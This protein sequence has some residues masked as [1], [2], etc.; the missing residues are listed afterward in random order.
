[1]YF[2]KDYQIWRYILIYFGILITI[3]W[4][5]EGQSFS[6]TLGFLVTRISL[7]L[8]H[9]KYPRPVPDKTFNIWSQ[10]QKI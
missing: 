8:T 10:L 3:V 6:N 5:N 4:E 1:M 2:K 7:F 9:R